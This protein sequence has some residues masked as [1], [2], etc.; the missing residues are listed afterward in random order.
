MPTLTLTDLRDPAPPVPGPAHRAA[1]AARAKQ[2][3]RRRRLAQIG[4]VCAVV[5]VLAIGG[6]A[7]ASSGTDQASHV[8][9]R[10]ANVTGTTTSPPV[11]TLTVT[12]TGDQKTVTVDADPSGTFTVSNLP[13]GDYL[14]EW[15]YE[16]SGPPPADGVDIGTSLSNGRIHVN[17]S[18]GD[19]T[20]RIPLS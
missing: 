9:V 2:L 15:T 17:L 12:F 19:N 6:V 4:G 8:V 20:V 16:T 10:A 14:V 11:S 5:A 7:I 13:P 3:T 18:S 1:V